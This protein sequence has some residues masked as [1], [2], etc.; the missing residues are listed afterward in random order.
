MYD[1]CTCGLCHAPSS[2]TDAY[3]WRLTGI[4][5]NVLRSDRCWVLIVQWVPFCPSWTPTVSPFCKMVGQL[6]LFLFIISLRWLLLKIH[7]G[8]T[9][10]QYDM[11]SVLS[12]TRYRAFAA[13]GPS[14]FFYIVLFHYIEA[15]F[16]P[17]YSS[18][19]DFIML[20]F[21]ISVN[22]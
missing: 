21:L 18:S 9:C 6:W 13:L 2:A 1:L 15:Y 7:V 5:H 14:Y 11:F 3:R 4:C 19:V 20:I 17:K 10:Q 16:T 22:L 8:S 12:I